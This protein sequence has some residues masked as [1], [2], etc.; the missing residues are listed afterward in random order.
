MQGVSIFGRGIDIEMRAVNGSKSIL[1][2][3]EK[4]AVI[5]DIIGYKVTNFGWFDLSG[6]ERRR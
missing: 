4:L 5:E 3:W 6:V 2:K 1:R